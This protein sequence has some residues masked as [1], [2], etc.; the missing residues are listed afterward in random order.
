LLAQ[1]ETIEELAV[2]PQGGRE[3][4]AGRSPAFTTRKESPTLESAEQVRIAIELSFP[5]SLKRQQQAKIQRL[6]KTLE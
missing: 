6:L 2:I 5:E 1:V 4:V 3:S